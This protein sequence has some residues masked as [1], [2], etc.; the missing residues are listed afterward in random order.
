MVA[1]PDP[2]HPDD[3]NLTRDVPRG[4]PWER[5]SIVPGAG[6]LDRDDG[7]LGSGVDLEVLGGA[8]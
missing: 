6:V 7:D 1:K 2:W 4:K 3:W 8:K 5:T